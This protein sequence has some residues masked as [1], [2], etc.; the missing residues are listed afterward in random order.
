MTRRRTALAGTGRAQACAQA[1]FAIGGS[2]GGVNRVS[3]R[4]PAPAACY[5]ARVIAPRSG[6][7][8]RVRAGLGG[9]ALALAGC[10]ASSAG[11]VPTGPVTAAGPAK[12]S[13]TP[14]SESEPAG[15]RGIDEAR[16]K[17]EA[18]RILGAVAK[19]RRLE[20]TSPVEVTITS[21]ADIRAFAIE[22]MREYITPEEMALQGRISASLGVIAAGASLEQVFLNILDAGVL[23]FYDPKKKTLFIG[24]FI[25]TSLLSQTVGHEIAHALQDMHF[26]LEPRMKP[27]P[28]RADLD[29]AETFLIEG[30]ANAAYFA[31]ITGED[32]LQAID[33]AVLEAS[34]DQSLELV[35][36]MSEAPVIARGLHLPYTAGAATVVRMVVQDGWK[37]VDALYDDPPTTTEQMMHVEKLRSREPARG[38]RFERDAVSKAL[39]KAV[40]WHD[41]FGE[42]QWL[43]LLAD[44]ES[45]SVARRSAA[46]WGGDTLL[47]LEQ[48]GGEMSVAIAVVMDAPS[49]AEELEASLRKYADERIEGGTMLARRRDTVLFVSGVPKGTDRKVLATAL[50]SA[51]TVDPVAKGGKR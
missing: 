42:A 38:I 1:S 41:E 26:G 27:T 39:G 28:H 48:P 19:A 21:K 11:L 15:T 36:I 5:A 25:S 31:W 37:S 35:S 16:A 32:G 14:G 18:A 7:P 40:V 17:E 46:G 9:L 50:W 29:S 23:G 6:V 2:T 49:D 45:A 13:G 47:A 10:S 33:D 22:N 51:L 24:D 3:H 12:T 4:E 43:A 34:I 30:G 20:A 44:V 8:R